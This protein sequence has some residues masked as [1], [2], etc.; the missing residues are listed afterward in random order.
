M[1]DKITAYKGFNKD[2]KCREFQYE[3][4]KEYEMEGDIKACERGFH[5]CASPL[6]VFGYYAPANSRYCVVEQSGELSRD[7]SDSKVASSKIAISA[8]IGILGL[9][10][11][12][13]EYT[14]SRTTM[15]HTDPKMATAGE[16]G[17]AT[18]GEC[19]AATAGDYGA[20]TAGD[21]GAAMA[22]DYGA[23]T[24]R[25]SVSVG[26]NGCGLVRGR[27]VKARGGRDAILTVCVEDER[28]NIAEWKSF[29]VDGETVKVDTW[30]TL[31]DGEVVEVDA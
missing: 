11:A 7:A 4:G 14:K 30:Y 3:I 15:E 10:T 2:L 24:S 13:I 19:G 22:G 31:K 1:R 26:E 12:H 18:A 28:G 29:V 20:A 8:E 16:C 23:A 21:Y 9:A 17:A 25:G 5:A 6:D 27:K